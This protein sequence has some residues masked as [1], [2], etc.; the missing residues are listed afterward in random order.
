MGSSLDTRTPNPPSSGIS[1]R[2][3]L[4]WGVAA[5]VVVAG[6]LV[7]ALTRALSPSRRISELST[8][9]GH[10]QAVNA[11]AWSPDS[12][13]IVSSALQGP[14]HIWSLSS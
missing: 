8:H 10:S 13:R 12:A 1:R 9:R 3:L 11:L 2:A 7:Y 14:V 5:G 4:G 6:G